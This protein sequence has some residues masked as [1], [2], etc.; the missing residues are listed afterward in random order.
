MKIAAFFIILFF[1]LNTFSETVKEVSLTGNLRNSKLNEDNFQK[2][3]SMTGSFA[4]YLWERTAVEFSYTQGSS[5]LQSLPTPTDSKVVIESDFKLFSGNF[6]T[7]FG[8]RKAP[9]QPYLK[10]G[11]GYMDK[12]ITR[13]VD[14]GS[15][16]LEPVTGIVP[17]AGAGIKIKTS[18]RFFIKL[19]GD[20]WASPLGGSEDSLDYTFRFGLSC[21]F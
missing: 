20:L 19:G 11:L 9:I 2:T 17:S 3:F 8:D 21:Y 4:I 16:Q 6:V 12:K 15:S 7:T 1:S 14:V 18:E 10:L 13:V 5:T